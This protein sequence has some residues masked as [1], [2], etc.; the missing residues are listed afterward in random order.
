MVG[1]LVLRDDVASSLL[2]LGSFAL[3]EDCC[4]VV[5]T[6]GWPVENKASG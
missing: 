4:P 1:D 3:G 5:K 2:C 6:L